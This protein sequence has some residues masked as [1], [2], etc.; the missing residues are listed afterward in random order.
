MELKPLRWYNTQKDYWECELPSPVGRITIRCES[1]KKRCGFTSDADKTYKVEGECLETESF[2]TLEDAQKYSH[3]EVDAFLKY[4]KH[5]LE[6]KIVKI[7]DFY[8]S[9]Y[10]W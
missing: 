3:D 8:K 9:S 2:A 6:Q 7:N 10:N 4:E 1:G 5:H